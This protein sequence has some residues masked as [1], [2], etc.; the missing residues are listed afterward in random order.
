MLE[1]PQGDDIERAPDVPSMNAAV[2]AWMAKR[3]AKSYTHDDSGDVEF[4]EVSPTAG[5]VDVE[6]GEADSQVESLLELEPEAEPVGP[7][8]V[9][10]PDPV[11]INYSQHLTDLDIQS[12]S[13]RQS[14]ESTPPEIPRRPRSRRPQGPVVVT[15]P[16]APRAESTSGWLWRSVASPGVKG[17]ATS[18]V[19]HMIVLTLLGWLVFEGK[20]V[21]SAL[22]L[23]G[24]LSDGTELSEIEL[25]SSLGESGGG[26]APVEFPD[27]LNIAES[28]MT[29][30]DPNEALSGA[31]SAGGLGVGTGDGAG[32]GNGEGT[33]IAVPQVGVPSYAVRK[34]S[35]AAWTEPRDPRPGFSYE[36]VIQFKLPPD[37]KTYRGSDLTGMVIGTDGYKQVIRFARTQQ[38]EVRDGSVQLR[39]RVPG[40]D[41]LVRDTIRVESRILREKQV[42]EI[43][44]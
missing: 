33:A 24:G 13:P 18:A 22:E 38:F 40:A 25:D 16:E 6:F 23:F 12:K 9:P 44:F 11:H 41:Q 35:F 42:L 43:V 28:G 19:L 37:V 17:L 26:S 2:P 21:G 29:S 20:R 30:F 3:R 8:P 31:F 1:P 34:G 14:A 5:D 27:V 39:V 15:A 4:A 7:P 10:A 36:I 32:D